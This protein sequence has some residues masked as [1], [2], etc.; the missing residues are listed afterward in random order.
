MSHT[1]SIAIDGPSAAG[2]STIARAL[3]ERLG[4]LYVDT[5]ALYRAIGYFAHTDGADLTDAAAI[6]MLLPRIDVRLIYLDGVQRIL[7][8]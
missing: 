8:N 3:A 5:G 4:F 6:E 7:L 2:K 1:V